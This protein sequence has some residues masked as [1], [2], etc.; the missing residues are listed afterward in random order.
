MAV[1][2]QLRILDDDDNDRRG[3][4]ND[5]RG[6]RRRIDNAPL[7]VRIRRQLL[8]L[9]ESPLRRWH[10]EVQGI[11]HL[12]ANNYDTPEV[13]NSFVELVLQM[14]VEQPLKTPFVA[15]VILV[16]NGLKPELVD[17]ILAKA[18]AA[19]ELKVKLGEWRDV[20]LYL[21]LLACLQGCLSD[22]GVFPLLEELFA[23]AVDLQT[24][25]SDDVRL[26]QQ[27][28]RGVFNGKATMLTRPPTDYRY[29]IGED[30]P[31]DDPVHSCSVTLRVAAA[32]SGPD[33]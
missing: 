33:G 14:S 13:R 16:V 17:D 29:R 3:P 18:A 22:D 4:D 9:A 20:K 26:P 25:S 21:K 7:P 32:G 8:G 30:H 11:A 31:P 19:T 15:A 10:E 2:N 27:L 24:A 12:V 5:R 23:R 6:P 28:A 1:A